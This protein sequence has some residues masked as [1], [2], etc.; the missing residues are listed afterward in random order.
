[1]LPMASNPDH[2]NLILCRCCFEK[3]LAFRRE[4]NRELAKDCAFQLPGWLS[5]EIYGEGVAA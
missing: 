2:G 4:R 5:L 1:M 3:E